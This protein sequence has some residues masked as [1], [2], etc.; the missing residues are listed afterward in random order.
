VQTRGH[1][2]DSSFKPIELYN[3]KDDIGESRNLAGKHPEILARLERL[4]NEAHH[5]LKSEQ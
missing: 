5:P 1:K 3:L 4:M 2:Q